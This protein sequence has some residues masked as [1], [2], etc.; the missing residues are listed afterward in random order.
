V[1]LAE[2]PDSGDDP[3][4]RPGDLERA[5]I[6]E[7]VAKTRQVAPVAVDEAAVAAARAAPALVRLEE[8][9]VEARV[10]LLQRERRPE[11]GI[12]AA[13]DRNVGFG[14]TLQRRR[15]LFCARLLEPPNVA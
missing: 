13:N 1:R 2:L 9:D 3:V 11:P 15:R 14:V 6:A 8:D 5:L 12:A 7:L 10:A 4:G